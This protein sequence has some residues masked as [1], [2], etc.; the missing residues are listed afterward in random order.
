MVWQISRNEDVTRQSF[1][2]GGYEL[3]GDSG[4][5]NVSKSTGRETSAHK[6]G[7]RVNGQKDDPRIAARFLQT[8]GGF[9]AIK[10]GHRNI[11]HNDLRPQPHGL[12]KQGLAIADLSN[13]LELR[14]QEPLFHLRKVRVIVCEKYSHFTQS[15]RP[16]H[17]RQESIMP[18]IGHVVRS[19]MLI[20]KRGNLD[21]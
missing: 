20:V 5:R 14:F 18:I 10:N 4:L 21:R 8:V 11:C 3:T 7:V 6:L 13:D 1:T 19:S 9:D 2:N 12:L 15:A 17:A 16:M